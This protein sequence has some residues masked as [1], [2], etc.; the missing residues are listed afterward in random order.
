MKIIFLH[1][2]SIFKIL[3]NAQS[4]PEK[5]YLETTFFKSTDQMVKFPQSA[6]QIKSFIWDTLYIYIIEKSEFSFIFKT[7]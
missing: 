6:N 3:H 7:S 4:A 2:Y 5:S 1:N